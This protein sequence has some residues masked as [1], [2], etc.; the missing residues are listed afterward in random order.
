MPV[1]FMVGSVISG[2]QNVV[3]RHKVV[4]LFKTIGF[5]RSSIQRKFVP[6]IVMR[7]MMTPSENKWIAIPG[8]IKGL[9]YTLSSPSFLPT[10]YA[11][12]SYCAIGSGQ[13]ATREIS[14]I[15]DWLLAGQPGNDITDMLA[16]TEAVS[17]FCAA[18]GI[19]SVGGT[20]P[21][22]KLD[23]RGVGCLGHS[24]G[25]PGKRISLEFDPSMRRWLQKNESTGKQLQ[26]LLPWEIVRRTIR[27]DQRFDDWRDAVRAFNPRRLQQRQP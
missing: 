23:Q 27:T 12:L 13:G 21:C 16:L 4:E 9:L 5:G 11:P 17:E 10:H 8:S 1:A 24:M 19:E 15:A 2:R 26:L 3:E 25:L 20:F 22:L 18:E 7:V 6:D 14:K